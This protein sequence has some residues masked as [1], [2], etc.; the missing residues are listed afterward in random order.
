MDDRNV[1]GVGKWLGNGDRP[2]GCQPRF[3][4]P[5]GDWTMTLKHHWTT[6]ETREQQS[7]QPHGRFPRQSVGREGRVARLSLWQTVV[8]RSRPE[9]LLNMNQI[10]QP[11]QHNTRTP[12]AWLGRRQI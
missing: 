4:R 12:E 6:C 1:V 10:R 9:G 8:G 3:V 7:P 11:T 5:W 2:S